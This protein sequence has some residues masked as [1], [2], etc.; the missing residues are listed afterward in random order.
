[1][2]QQKLTAADDA[3]HWYRAPYSPDPLILDSH[4]YTSGQAPLTFDIIDASN[5]ADPVG[6]INLLITAAPL[7]HND[8]ASSLTTEFLRRHHGP[9]QPPIY[10]LLCD[11]FLAISLSLSLFPVEYWT[12]ASFKLSVSDTILIALQKDVGKDPSFFQSSDLAESQPAADG[13]W[14]GLALPRD[15]VSSTSTSDESGD[16]NGEDPG[17]LLAKRKAGSEAL[18]SVY[19]H[20]RA[21]YITFLRYIKSMVNSD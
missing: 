19:Y 18:L 2:L 9:K 10:G 13:W 21:S 4:D 11:N 1:M 6:S 20:A 12:N 16:A 15:R 5:L 3:A 7:L 8:L 17:V 14:S